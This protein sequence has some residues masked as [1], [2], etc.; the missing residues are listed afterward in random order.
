M[1]TNTYLNPQK[2]VEIDNKLIF[3]YEYLKHIREL[4]D[5]NIG[6]S[7]FDDCEV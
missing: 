1:L 4:P 5:G 2:Q 3:C 6:Y 7:A